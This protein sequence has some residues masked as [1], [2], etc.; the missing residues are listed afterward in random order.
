MGR[1]RFV[2][3]VT[4]EPTEEAP[5]ELPAT[6]AEANSLALLAAAVL[7]IVLLGAVTVMGR[8]RA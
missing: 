2:R 1:L 4:P 8:R 5:E 6:G 3:V 7:T